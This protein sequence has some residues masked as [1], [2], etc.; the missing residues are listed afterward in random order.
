MNLLMTFG[1]MS[2]AEAAEEYERQLVEHNRRA[3]GQ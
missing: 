1:G 2:Q 3:G